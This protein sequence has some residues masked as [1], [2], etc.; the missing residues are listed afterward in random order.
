MYLQLFQYYD[1][2]AAVIIHTARIKHQK[3]LRLSSLKNILTIK[4]TAIINKFSYSAIR[5]ISQ[6]LTSLSK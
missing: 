6:Y 5:A 2:C 4:S 1:I 3:N